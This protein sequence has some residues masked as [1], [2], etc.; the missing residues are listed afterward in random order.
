MDAVAQKNQH[1]RAWLLSGLVVVFLRALPNLRFPIGRDQATYCLIGQGLLRG[2]LLYRDLWDNKPPGIFYIYALIVKIF[3]PVM[4]CVGAVDILWLLVISLC[5]F[6]F[7]RR[8]LGAP[9]AS[10]AMVANA[11]RHCR[12]GYIHAAQPET[13]LMLCVFAAWFLLSGSDP[14]PPFV[15]QGPSPQGRGQGVPRWV[16]LYLAAGLIL[17]FGFWLKYNAVAFFPFVA[18]APFLDF[19]EVDTDARRLRLLIPW[20]TWITRMCAVGAGFLIAIFG[21]VIYFWLVGAWPAMREVQ[22]EVLPRYGARVF[23]WNMGFLLWAIRQSQNHLGYWTEVMVPLTLLI[24]WRRR[25]LARVAPA[26]LLGFAGYLAAAMQGRFHPYYFE[27]CYPFFS[28]FW[29]YV[30]VKTVEGFAYLR[31]MFAERQWTLARALL[32]V[33]LVVVFGSVLSEDSVRVVEHYR[34]L[35]DW[36]RNPEMSYRVYWWQL[37]L[38]KFGGQLEV[39]NYLKAHSRP[40]DEIYVWGTAPLIN[41]LTQRQNPSR[42]VSNLA[43]IS[44]WAPDRWRQE[45]VGTLATKR[46]RYIVVARHDSIPSVSYTFDDSEEYLKEYPALDHLL[47]TQYN[48]DVNFWD[49]EIYRLK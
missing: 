4:W 26:L 21:L 9:A 33:V 35:E 39:I 17:G 34:F 30:L 20:K 8:Y 7:A 11:I 43:L 44:T 27:T 28:M 16:V 22:F 6:Y 29:G 5:I 25:E 36:W 18:L 12:Q 15:P 10:L 38:D 1:A 24:A 46:P 48:V 32:W 49:F 47:K 23:Q 37:P 2:Q 14:S 40:Q 19:R 13:F 41:F 3:G 31:R 42:F 45:L